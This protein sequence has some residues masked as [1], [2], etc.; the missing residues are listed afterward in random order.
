MPRDIVRSKL[1]RSFDAIAAEAAAASW[2]EHYVS[3]ALL[4]LAVAH[5]KGIMAKF[6][7]EA[8]ITTATKMVRA[9]KGKS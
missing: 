7:T 8:D 1:E 6:A 9:M 5:V 4:N 2:S 3:T